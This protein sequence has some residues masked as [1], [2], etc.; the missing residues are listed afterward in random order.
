MRKLLSST[1]QS[2]IDSPE[3]KVMMRGIAED[4]GFEQTDMKKTFIFSLN[5]S[6]N[7]A[8]KLKIRQFYETELLHRWW[9][10]FW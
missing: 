5:K 2:V 1:A 9:R 6:I 3:F 4:F 7:F 8:S 10:L